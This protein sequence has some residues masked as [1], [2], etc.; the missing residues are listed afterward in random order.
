MADEIAAG[1]HDR[2]E[3]R[4]F[5]GAQ[6]FFEGAGK[7][8]RVHREALQFEHRR[9]M[10]QVS[11]ATERRLHRVSSRNGEIVSGTDK[12]PPVVRLSDL[13]A[14]NEHFISSGKTVK[15]DYRNYGR[16]SLKLGC[17]LGYFH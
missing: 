14:T 12:S 5:H 11:A 15:G 8:V 1:E 7:G 9:A 16:L 10:G 17:G 2:P 13:C 3:A 6:F 4:G